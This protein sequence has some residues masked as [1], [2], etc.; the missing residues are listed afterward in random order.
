[1]YSDQLGSAPTLDERRSE[2][3]PPPVAS[4][5]DRRRLIVAW[6]AGLL[7]F[8]AGIAVGA[9]A[10]RSSTGTVA[11]AAIGS[12]LRRCRRGL[13]CAAARSGAAS[14]PGPMVAV[15]HFARR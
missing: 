14:S 2:S 10:G 7:L 4:R 5:S 9:G 12:R 13:R 15:E 1:M 8:V 3:R 6:S 11:G